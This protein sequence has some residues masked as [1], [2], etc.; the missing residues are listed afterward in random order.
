VLVVGEL[1]LAA[2]G[3]DTSTQPN[4]AA[5]NAPGLPSASAIATFQVN[6]TADAVDAA[7]GN[8]VC[9]TGG[10]R[11]T[12][13]AAIQESNALAGANAITLPAGTYGLTLPPKPGNGDASGSIEITD[14]LRITGAGAAKT[15]IDGIALRNQGFTQVSLKVVGSAGDVTITNLTLQNGGNATG[16]CGGSNLFVDAGATVVLRKIIV[17]DGWDYCA[18]GG[19]RNSGTLSMDQSII[20]SNLSASSGG[21]LSN[22][23]TLK[24]G[25]TTI[26]SNFA[27]DGDGG[28]SNSGQLNITNATLSANSSDFGAGGLGNG[29]TAVLNNVTVTKN[30]SGDNAAV[31]TYGSGVTQVSNTII[32]GNSGPN[33]FG[34]LTSGGYNLLGGTTGCTVAGDPTGNLVGAPKLGPLQNNGG[35]TPTH[36]LLAAS[37][38]RDAGNP[39]A[40]GAGPSACAATDQRLLPRGA[41]RCDIGSVE[42]Q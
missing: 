13:R 8:G 31:S 3:Q 33:C 37:P 24:I 42:M 40:P 30:A 34:T 19:I 4:P 7:P 38:A 28:I 27:E 18:A 20:T 5:D 16:F 26:D 32:G 14:P 25:R 35:P 15:I 39:A 10:G 2:C 23:G 21:G 1:G 6:S 41:T 11:C 36:A 9:R 29:G 22:R 12:L 17:R